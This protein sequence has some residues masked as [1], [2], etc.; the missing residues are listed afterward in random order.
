MAVTLSQF[1]LKGE[2]E[3]YCGHRAAAAVP[4][5]TICPACGGP[6]LV[7][8]VESHALVAAESPT[9]ATAAKYS[10]HPL[11]KPGVEVFVLP[12]AKVD[13]R[14]LSPLPED[15]FKIASYHPEGMADYS[16]PI[17][18]MVGGGWAPAGGVVVVHP[19]GTQVIA[20]PNAYAS[21][22]EKV[23]TKNAHCGRVFTIADNRATATGYG[24]SRCYNMTEYFWVPYDGVVPILPV[25]T[26]VRFK[27]KPYE[28][29]KVTFE[30]DRNTGHVGEIIE[31]RE[32]GF[33]SVNGYDGGEYIIKPGAFWVPCYGV[34]E[35][36]ED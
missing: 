30:K 23:T 20:K 16:D 8:A 29:T 26:K 19:P 7:A 28:G 10:K 15:F 22:N 36:V 4:A 3:Y 12:L 11:L 31:F 27:D 21:C 17:V 5:G 24:I 34:E 13:W 32:K 14:G 25:G 18:R 33:H 1:I 9:P 6:S 35:L 2:H